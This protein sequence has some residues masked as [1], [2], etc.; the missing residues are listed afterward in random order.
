MTSNQCVNKNALQ[1]NYR[2]FIKRLVV[3]S[4]DS[5]ELLN[6]EA[7]LTVAWGQQKVSRPHNV[8]KY[9]NKKWF[10]AV[11]AGTCKAARIT[12]T[13]PPAETKQRH[14]QTWHCG[15]HSVPLCSDS[16]FIMFSP[17]SE[18]T[19]F[20]LGPHT[21]VGMIRS[22]KKKKKPK[23]HAA[24]TVMIINLSPKFS[25]NSNQKHLNLLIRVLLKNDTQLCK[26]RA[27]I[28]F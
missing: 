8:A 15:V 2:W 11:S 28:I 19:R 4:A 12:K 10:F 7:R 20:L 13:F 14:D 9:T 16:S 24:L 23:M 26:S 3:C 25:S 17:Y 22:T 21:I 5:W 18:N 1:P 27:E 6:L